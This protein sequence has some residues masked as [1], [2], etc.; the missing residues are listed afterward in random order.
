MKRQHLLISMIGLLL[1]FLG[2][3]GQYGGN[4]F[5]ADQGATIE[6]VFVNMKLSQGDHFKSE[7]LYNN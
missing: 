4:V 5:E 3:C 1:L 6:G 7:P 2:A